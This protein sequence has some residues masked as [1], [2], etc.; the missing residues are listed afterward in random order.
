MTAAVTVQVA[1]LPPAAIAIGDAQVVD[2]IKPPAAGGV[3]ATDKPPAGA[4]AL[5]V[6]VM[7]DT[8]PAESTKA[9]GDAAT[10]TEGT[11][12]TAGLSVALPVMLRSTAPLSMSSSQQTLVGAAKAAVVV[13]ANDASAP[14]TGV[15]HVPLMS[16]QFR[17]MY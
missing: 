16:A 4:A 7:V 5:E 11:A 1:V 2:A 14:E 6:K 13:T 8:L 3:I 17:T 9:A 10:E 12:D 15:G